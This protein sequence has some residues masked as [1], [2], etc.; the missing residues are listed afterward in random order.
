MWLTIPN[1]CLDCQFATIDTYED[2][3][4]PHDLPL[5]SRLANI[6]PHVWFIQYYNFIFLNLQLFLNRIIVQILRLQAAVFFINNILLH[7]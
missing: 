6:A 4:S 7:F 1:F 3:K 5:E 2:S